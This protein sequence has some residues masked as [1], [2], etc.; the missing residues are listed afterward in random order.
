[1]RSPLR[2]E[3]TS[4]DLINDAAF[5]AAYD[6]ALNLLHTVGARRTLERLMEER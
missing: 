1:M 5:V 6:H 2:I 3:S 4:V